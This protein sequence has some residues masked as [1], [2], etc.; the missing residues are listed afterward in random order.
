MQIAM[1]NHDQPGSA[2]FAPASGAWSV[3]ERMQGF[4]GLALGYPSVAAKA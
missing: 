3:L 1:H 2:R 4:R